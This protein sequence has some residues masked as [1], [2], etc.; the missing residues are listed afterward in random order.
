MQDNKDHAERL[1]RYNRAGQVQYEWFDETADYIEWLEGRVD[2]LEKQADVNKQF[3]ERI[4]R[5]YLE[6]ENLTWSP[7][8]MALYAATLL[9]I[10]GF[11][12]WVAA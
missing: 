11:I 1:R 7:R 3:R 5:E 12:F 2:A 10:M 8:E 9:L 4:S 6:R